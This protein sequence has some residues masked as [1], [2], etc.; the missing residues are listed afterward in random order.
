LTAAGKKL[1]FKYVLGAHVIKFT[2]KK[3]Q[4]LNRLIKWLVIL[5]A[6]AYVP[7][8]YA[9]V[10]ENLVILGVI[11]TAAY[12]FMLFVFLYPRAS[13]R[14]RLLSTVFITLL[15][16]AAVLFQTGTSGAGHVW[17]IC[18]VFIA[19]LFGKIPIMVK[20]ILITQLVMIVYAVLNE[21]GVIDHDASVISIAAISANMLIVSVAL[22][23]VTH[24]LLSALQEEI[25]EQEKTLQLLDHR[26]RNNLQTIESL[27]HLNDTQPDTP[28]VLSRRI[29]AISEA[30]KL[31]LSN[32][33]ALFVDLGTLLRTISDAR[34]VSIFIQ[35]GIQVSP[36]KLT[37]I[38]VGLSDLLEML[39]PFGPL[40]VTV[41]DTV[42]IHTASE[43]PNPESLLARTNESVFIQHWAV[44]YE[45][46]DGADELLV[47]IPV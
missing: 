16:G 21:V 31:V 27:V 15:L 24:F 42:R 17:L 6:V 35:K 36:E 13:F 20:T 30:N 33:S 40:Q 22:S 46:A 34:S 37:E 4:L 23:L 11:D 43:L 41:E 1:S 28:S 39:K 9:C 7:S 45:N 26:V 29:H 19:A 32:P 2:L 8:I 10:K 3:E 12:L 5:G 47:T 14:L 38:V 44:F 25:G 18:S